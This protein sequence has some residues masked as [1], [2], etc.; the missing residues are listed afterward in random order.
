MKLD[1]Q[2]APQAASVSLARRSVKAAITDLPAETAGRLELIVSELVTNCVLHAGTPFRI[3]IQS[4]D[5]HV[6]GE[7]SDTGTG[8]PTMRSP[9][10]HQTHGHGLGIVA[11]LAAEWGVLNPPA[12]PG[13]TVWFRLD[14]M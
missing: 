1:C 3:T 7:I 8:L 4:T 12:G 6:Y 11:R 2:L 14:A 13:K 10:G 5:G 9:N